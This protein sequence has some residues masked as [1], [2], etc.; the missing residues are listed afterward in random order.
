M[1][2]V[3][4]RSL[5]LCQAKA[6]ICQ[7]SSLK[8]IWSMVKEADLQTSGSDFEATRELLK[9]Q[10]SAYVEH[11]T[12]AVPYQAGLVSLPMGERQ[13]VNLLDCLRGQ[14]R[15]FLGQRS[16]CCMMMT[17]WQRSE[18]VI[19]IRRPTVI[20]CYGCRSSMEGF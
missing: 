7:R 15:R 14:A 19:S 2:H 20:R 16:S 8:N 9:V 5:E 13:P 4:A 10:K 18:I 3:G 12:T 17:F 11:C 1:P 6:S